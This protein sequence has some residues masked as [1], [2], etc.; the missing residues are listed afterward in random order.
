MTPGRPATR[1]L[2]PYFCPAC[3]KRLYQH[4]KATSYRCNCG[5][6]YD[7]IEGGELRPKGR[8]VKVVE[9]ARK[10]TG[11]GKSAD[12]YE[13]LNGWEGWEPAEGELR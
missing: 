5:R 12:E 2:C 1:P 9:A 8:R 4:G 10:Q 3:G 13:R 6:S 7:L 11:A